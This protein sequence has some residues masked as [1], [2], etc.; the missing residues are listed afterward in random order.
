MTNQDLIEQLEELSPQE[1]G[2][3]LLDMS[4]YGVHIQY[5]KQL[6]NMG[7]SLDIVDNIQDKT[8]L[9]WA[10][11][12]NN[13]ELIRILLEAKAP[14]D[15]LSVGKNSVLHIAVTNGHTTALQ[16]LLGAKAPLEARDHA[17]WTPLH[18]AARYGPL[19]M[20]KPSY[21]PEPPRRPWIIMAEPPGI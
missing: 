18:C 17:G 8:A 4:R 9:H 1:L 16:D 6:I 7:A 20:S 19:H 11:S 15:I 14:L 2:E 21:K 13:I 10:V 3:I 5:I 12:A